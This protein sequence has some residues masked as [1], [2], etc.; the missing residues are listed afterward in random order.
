[1]VS[2][3]NQ[4]MWIAGSIYVLGV[5]LSPIV[6]GFLIKKGDVRDWD[7]LL[8]FFLYIFWPIVL[9]GFIAFVIFGVF[10]LPL[11]VV[12]ALFDWLVSV[13]Q[14]LRRRWDNRKNKKTKEN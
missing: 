14:D 13:G 5:F 8:L 2:S 4:I 10:T 9:V 7:V 11:I 1:M 3:T 12:G 6:W